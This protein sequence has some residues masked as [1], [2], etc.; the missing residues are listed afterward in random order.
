MKEK[1]L[2]NDL[3][4]FIKKGTCAFTTVEEIKNI[5]NEENYQELDEK[6]DYKLTPGKYYITRNDATIIAINIPKNYLKQ[7]AICTT[8]CDTPSLM[9]KQNGENTKNNYLKHNIMPYGGLLNYGWLDHYL[10]LSGR[11]CIKKNNS[12]NTK[13]IDIAKP[14]AIIPS[15][16]IHLNDK[17]NSNLDLNMQ[18]D[19]QPIFDIEKNTKITDYLKNELNITD[20]ICDY[21]LYLY[22]CEKPQ[23]IGESSNILSSPRIDN[24]T[25]T[26]TALKGFLESKN[27][28]INIYVSFNS[29][30]IG[31][32][33]KEGAESNFLL[34]I[35]KKIATN[36]NFDLTESLAKTHLISADNT[37]AIHPNHAELMDETGNINLNKGIAIIKEMTSTT[38]GYFSSILKSILDKNKIPYQDSSIKN[39]LAAGSTLAGLNLKHVSVSSIEIGIGELAM[40]SSIECCGTKDI[41][42]MYETF[43]S[44][45]SCDI[46]KERKKTKVI[47]Y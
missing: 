37:H 1:K 27:Q 30:E 33:T 15:V 46:I 16:A 24:L 5:L 12:F 44:F 45:Y 17:A 14:I 2:I 25:S 18:T 43:K 28:S 34:N 20:D 3:I 42:Y 8:H 29:E 39:D 21:D 11:I 6:D 26:Y 4:T 40:H 9:L 22:N 41:Y 38:D 47:F 32:V 7:F 36:L 35:L 31:S 23:I 13:I 19:L 10:S